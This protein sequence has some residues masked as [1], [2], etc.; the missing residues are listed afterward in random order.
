MANPFT[1]GT[2]PIVA[3]TKNLKR[4]DVRFQN[5][6]ETT[7]YFARSPI[8]PTP[9]NY[10]FSIV[11]VKSPGESGKGEPNDANFITNSTAQFN[12][13]SSGAGGLLAI[14]ETRRT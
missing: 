6:G 7:L 1:V 8:V 3:I 13:V 4:V 10:E 9:T 11:G 5:V 12:V 14:F 2:S